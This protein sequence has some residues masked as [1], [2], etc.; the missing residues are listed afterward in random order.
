MVEEIKQVEQVPQVD[1]ITEA[2]DVVERIEK[3][4]AAFQAES[5]RLERLKSDDI[6]AGR[7]SG[8]IPMPELSDEDKKK[9]QA[10]EFW[11]GTPIAE[12]IAKQH[13]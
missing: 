10:V 8:R 4:T 3:A 9:Q 2:R 1:R 13:G 6:L 11:K 7:S 5:A 12:A